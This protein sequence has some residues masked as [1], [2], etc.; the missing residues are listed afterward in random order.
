MKRLVLDTSNKYLY[1]AVI[2]D[3]QI[4]KECIKEGNN[5]H[6]ETLIKVLEE[7]LKEVKLNINDIDEVYVGRGPGSYTGIRVACTFAKV[8]TFIRQKKLFSFSS[9]DLLLT[10]NLQKGIIVCQIDARRGFSFAKV[11]EV[12]DE[13][14]VIKE[15]EF[16]ETSKLEEEFPNATFITNESYNYNPMILFAKNL[17]KEE[18]NIHQFV[19]TYLRSGV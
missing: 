6:S 2:E 7:T 5:N 4:I 16:I 17:V 13:I 14:K 18:T 15:E 9:L 12:T 8:F 11:F 19:P 10:T 3:E 1:I